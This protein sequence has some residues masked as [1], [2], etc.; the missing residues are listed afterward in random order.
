MALHGRLDDLLS[1][2]DLVAWGDGE[3][4]GFLTFV[5]EDARLPVLSLDA[6]VSR[7]GAGTALLEPR[8]AWRGGLALH[9]FGSPPPTSCTMYADSLFKSRADCA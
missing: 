2:D 9:A 1:A 3:R 5:N 6:D 8:Q 4:L 7:G